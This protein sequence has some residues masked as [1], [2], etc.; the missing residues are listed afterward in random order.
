M[1]GLPLV[2]VTEFALGVLATP[3]PNRK[4]GTAITDER[5]FVGV[6][7]EALT[8][9]DELVLTG[10]FNSSTDCE[11]SPIRTDRVVSRRCETAV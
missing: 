11:F 9:R 2:D 7:R 5:E 10:S 3:G 6:S 8:S 1:S 4:L